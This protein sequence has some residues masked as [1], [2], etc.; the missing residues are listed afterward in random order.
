MVRMASAKTAPATS[1]GQAMPPAVLIRASAGTGK[2]HQLTNWYLRLLARGVHPSRILAVT[3]TRKAAGEILRRVVERLVRA[4]SS[5]ADAEALGNQLGITGMNQSLAMSL[6]GGLT[7]NLH[8][9]RIST[10]DAFF[11][12]F[13]MRHAPSL[14]LPFGWSLTGD[15]TPL[16]NRGLARTMNEVGEVELQRLLHWLSPGDAAR[17]VADVLTKTVAALHAMF[18]EARTEGRRPWTWV[19]RVL[20]AIPS[21]ILAARLD[22]D[23]LELACACLEDIAIEKV[24]LGKVRDKLLECVRQEDWMGFIGTK[25]VGTVLSGG[26]KHGNTPIPNDLSAAIHPLAKHAR[27]VHAGNLVQF[28]EGAE[29]LLAHFDRGYAAVKREAGLY[30]FDDL[31][32][33][34]VDH[35]VPAVTATPPGPGGRRWQTS[36]AEIDHLLLDEFQDTSLD[37]WEAIQPYVH[38]VRAAPTE[39]SFFCVGDRKQ[40]IYEWRGGIPELLG[41]VQEEH[42]A[43]VLEDLVESRRSCQAVIDV[44]NQVHTMLGNHDNLGKAVAAVDEWVREFPLHRTARNDLDGYVTLTV[45][46]SIHEDSTPDAAAQESGV[47]LVR[48]LVVQDP[49]GTVAVLMQS[50][51]AAAEFLGRLRSEGIDASESGGVPLSDSAPGRLIGSALTL[52]DHPDDTRSAH[53]LRHSPLAETFG[54]DRDPL[55]A[56]RIHGAAA[57]ERAALIADGYGPT[58]ARWVALLTSECDALERF[59]ARQL[60]ELT[61]SCQFARGAVTAPFRQWLEF[62]RIPASPAESRVTVMTI[63]KAKGLEFDH[64]VLCDLENQLVRSTEFVVSRDPESLR[65]RAI[66][67]YPNEELRSILP[68]DLV[69][70]YEEDLRRRVVERLANLYV[71]MTRA[72]HGLHLIVGPE[73]HQRKSRPLTFAGLILSALAPDADKLLPGKELFSAGNLTWRRTPSTAVM[74]PAD[75]PAAHAD[76]E[77]AQGNLPVA[78]GL[79]ARAS[80]DTTPRRDRMISAA[81]FN[82]PSRLE[83]GGEVSV[84]SLFQEQRR[85]SMHRGTL[86]HAWLERFHWIDEGPPAPTL[87][88]LRELGRRMGFAGDALEIPLARLQQSLISPALT[89]I[90]S[91]KKFAN[92]ATKMSRQ[93]ESPNVD[94]EI[95]NESYVAGEVGTGFL[96]GYIDRLV[97]ARSPAGIVSAAIIDYKT[98]TLEGDSATV[99]RERAAVYA[100]Q[101]KGYRELLAGSL[102]LSPLRI[103]CWLVFLHTDTIWPLNDPDEGNTP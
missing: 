14:G 40:S 54:C 65:P 96:A 24:S 13:A 64:V 77:I 38:R 39:R 5:S 50:N 79:T 75:Q 93:W 55:H 102:G 16:R 17:S 46:E 62:A 47:E 29:E 21:R 69:A 19:R 12:E 100:P 70:I 11:A 26:S 30:Q 25:I 6:L 73:R 76:R 23:E 35:V 90:L 95:R 91:R 86:L 15:P 57:R 103:G 7:S 80:K 27:A 67:R 89:T 10:L 43:I 78:T 58:V 18:L 101:M 22:R 48:R 41:R 49:Q 8:T 81:R 87:G 33:T 32:R 3:F 1:F 99:I 82:A 88:E 66:L 9:L 61:Y 72:V 53:H 52:I 37:Q 44:V 60:Q 42:S 59:R 4:A 92:L 45:G 63:H 71:A 74:E 94:M 2:T 97:L 85:D 68:N 31:P 36:I 34:L 51:D 83:A 28:T 20:E 56:A 84:A 98:D